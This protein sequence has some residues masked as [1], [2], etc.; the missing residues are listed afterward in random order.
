MKLSAHG[1]SLLEILIGIAIAGICG[2]IL[3]SIM[4]QTNGVFF[5]QTVGISQG[6]SLNNSSS[7][8]NDL[9]SLS[10][11]VAQNYPATLPSQYTT[12]LNT[13]VLA[14]PSINSSGNVID[15]TFDY[16]VISSDST[17]PQVLRKQIFPNNL[18]SR[19]AEN[20]VLSTSLSQIKFLYFNDSGIQVPPSQATKINFTINLSEATGSKGKISS[21]SGQVNLKNN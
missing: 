9:I 3:V 21:A 19:K 13:L 17:I 10:Q 15:N 16:A 2:A 20:K 11:S 5:Q 4:F 7:Q 8:I 18:S 12:G 14:L 6:L 1:L